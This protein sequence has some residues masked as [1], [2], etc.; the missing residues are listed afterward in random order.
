MAINQFNLQEI[1][2]AS[3]ILSYDEVNRI[4]PL[5]SNL[6]QD[7]QVL[8]LDQAT[9]QAT[10][11]I[12]LRHISNE[13]MFLEAKDALESIEMSE[14]MLEVFDIAEQVVKNNEDNRV[15]LASSIP[16]VTPEKKRSLSFGDFQLAGFAYP[17]SSFVMGRETS[18]QYPEVNEAG[19][20]VDVPSFVL[21]ATEISQYQWALFLDDNP[22]WDKSN[23]S[24]LISKGLVDD[25][26]LEG[27]T[28]SS[29]FI[30]SRPV[31]NVSY[32]AAQAFCTWLSEKTGKE[33]FL[34]TE[35]MWSLAV[36]Q[37]NELDYTTS[38]SPSPNISSGPVSLMGGVW[39]LTQTPYIPLSRL[40]GYEES[41]ALHEA[42]SLQMQPVVKG[43]SYLNDPQTIT[44]H[45]VGV[46]ES[47]ACGDQIGFRVAWYD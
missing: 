47:N 46:I 9:T 13:R 10:L 43:G 37:Q 5:F 19:V 39:E 8:E 34:P 2:D 11:E 15:G 40:T 27:M 17:L 33:V 41:L 44:A 4:R 7:L 32:H 18:S 45:T 36:L 21:G 14:T 3:A 25:S 38:L 28:I 1:A 30:T 26:Y 24:E 20:S 35:A 23:K 16:S 22:Y 31:F 29:V 6:V 42:F 12:A